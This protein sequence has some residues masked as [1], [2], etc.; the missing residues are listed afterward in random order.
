MCID[1]NVNL[2]CIQ[3]KEKCYLGKEKCPWKQTKN[4]VE[5]YVFSMVSEQIHGCRN[6]HT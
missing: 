3:Y 4:L 2:Y 5:N 1:R 6:K